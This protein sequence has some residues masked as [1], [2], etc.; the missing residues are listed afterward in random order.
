MPADIRAEAKRRTPVK[1][2]SADP[3]VLVP[4]LGELALSEEAKNRAL[5]RSIWLYERCRR[6]V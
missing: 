5:S 4:A 1:R 2:G 6:A 3:S